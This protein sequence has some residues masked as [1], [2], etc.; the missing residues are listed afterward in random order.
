MN[1]REESNS[2]DKAKVLVTGAT[3][4][5]GKQLLHRLLQED[6]F[7]PI[8]FVRPSS[9]TRSL[10]KGVEIREGSLFEH[11]SLREAVRDVAA[12]VHLAAMMDFFPKQVE[13][14]YRTNVEGTR[15]LFLACVEERNSRRGHRLGSCKKAKENE[16]THAASA[17]SEETEEGDLRFIY[18]S[19]TEAMGAVESP[20]ADETTELRP[21][22]DYGRSKVL[23]EQIVK[24]LSDKHKLPHII[25]RPTG[26]LGPHDEF[27]FYELV[28]MV[29]SG[30]LCFIPGDGTA[31]LAFTHVE[32]VVEGIVRALLVEEKEEAFNQTYILSVDEAMTYAQWVRFLSHAC[33]RF[34]PF[35]HVPLPLVKVVTALLAPVMNLGKARVFMYNTETVDRMKEHRAFSNK[36]AKQFLGWHP[37]YSLTEAMQHTIDH[38][39]ATGRIK[40]YRLSPFLVLLL[41]FFCL[42]SVG[43]LFICCF[44]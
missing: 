31:L 18:I 22:S 6:R 43:Y 32:D 25:L 28:N 5:V 15:N 26:I 39:F 23:A 1:A 10:P 41:S 20:P 27:A 40:R 12:V 3:G 37:K 11:G 24:E 42:L 9:N 8:A 29:N 30:L 21:T 36:K 14:V 33:G 17:D 7:Q 4:F 2:K 13:Q 19:S 35:L 16:M 44:K 34:S 38:Y